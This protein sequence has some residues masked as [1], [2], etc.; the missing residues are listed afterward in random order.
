M[1]LSKMND[2]SDPT[3]YRVMLSARLLTADMECHEL[4]HIIPLEAGETIKW[5]RPVA[6]VSPDTYEPRQDLVMFQRDANPAGGIYDVIYRMSHRAA[7]QISNVTGR[8]VIW[9]IEPNA[10]MTFMVA[11]NKVMED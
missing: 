10:Y 9:G 4:S 6:V 3:E 1:N 5:I 8:I 2:D 11:I 7:V